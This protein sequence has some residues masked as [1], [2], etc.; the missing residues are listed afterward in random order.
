MLRRWTASRELIEQTC[1]AWNA[2]HCDPPLEPG[3]VRSQVDG[4]MKMEGGQE[5]AKA[6]RV[7]LTEA[8][9]AA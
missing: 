1:L 9:V 4:A 7:K 5:L 8:P 6:S 3:Q 2:S